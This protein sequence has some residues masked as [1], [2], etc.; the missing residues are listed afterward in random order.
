MTCNDGNGG[1]QSSFTITPGQ[2]TTCTFNN[3][4]VGGVGGGGGGG[5]GQGYLKI[6]S[7]APG[8][9]GVTFN[10]IVGNSSLS[11]SIQIKDGQGEFDSGLIFFGTYPVSETVTPGWTQTDVI[12]DNNNGN[13]SVAVI[14]FGQTT[15]CTFTNAKISVS[16]IPSCSDPDNV[17]LDMSGNLSAVDNSIY[18]Y[19]LTGTTTG[20]G[21]GG[22]DNT[23]YTYDSN[24]S[25]MAVHSGAVANGVDAI[26]K[27]TLLPGQSSYVGSTQNG[28]KTESYNP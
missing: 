25:A 28:V 24:I 2:T 17:P 26:V 10:F 22:A 1:T 15:T 3:T 16:S 12:C 27:V 14:N 13:P 8:S 18:Y 7:K 5:G 4:Y 6:I 23:P 20:L 19:K 21:W 11:P 9:D